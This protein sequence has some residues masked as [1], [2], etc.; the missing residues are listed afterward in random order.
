[1]DPITCAHAHPYTA[2]P[3]G[4]FACAC[5]QLLDVTDIEPDTGRLWTVDSAGVLVLLDDPRAA[6]AA[7]QGAVQNL[8]EAAEY[9]CP[10]AVREQATQTLRGALAA[11]RVAAAHGIR[12]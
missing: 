5:G 6:L 1:M 12:P 4:T 7:L 2:Q 3:D 8:R 9:P 11:L 10:Q